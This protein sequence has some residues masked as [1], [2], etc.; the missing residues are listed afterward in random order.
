M[1]Q[2]GSACKIVAL[3]STGAST[4]LL[5]SHPSMSLEAR[6]L[7]P[8]SR[9]FKVSTRDGIC[10]T[11]CV[12]SR[13][14][15]PQTAIKRHVPASVCSSK[16][17]KQPPPS[18]RAQSCLPSKAFFPRQV[19]HASST[20]TLSHTHLPFPVA[21]PRRLRLRVSAPTP[22][23]MHRPGPRLINKRDPFH[24]VPKIFEHTTCHCPLVGQRYCLC[25]SLARLWPS[26]L[27][28]TSSQTQ[29]R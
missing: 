12:R 15:L 13:S 26:C 4:V 14:L 8:S 23:F 11:E 1:L 7:Q 9:P 17:D 18:S 10:T 5:L 20:L 22:D 2:H 29:S 3:D 28:H 27:D 6:T 24:Q 25:I 16:P 19:K 21:S